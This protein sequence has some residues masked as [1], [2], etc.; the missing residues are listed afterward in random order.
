LAAIRR[1]AEAEYPDECCGAMLGRFGGAGMKE[2][3]E[4]RPIPNQREGGARR[5]RFLIPA[6]EMFALEK[7][8]CSAGLEVLG[9]YH[10]HPDHPA[11][12]SGYDLDHAWPGYS[13]LIVAV[14]GGAAGEALSWELT[15]D[16]RAFAAEELL[17]G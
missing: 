14:P 11:R 2:T 1:Q 8:A 12:P 7:Y 13:Y 10:S 4:I 9:F 16:R 15:P 17:E 6:A 3:A 5:R